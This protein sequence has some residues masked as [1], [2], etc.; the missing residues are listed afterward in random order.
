MICRKCKKEV[1]D[2]KYCSQCGASQEAKKHKPRRANGTGC[3]YK[4]SGNRSKP[5]RAVRA[6]VEDDDGN[7]IR[8]ELGTYRTKADAEKALAK[9]ALLPASEYSNITLKALFEMWKTTRAY[10][11]LSKQTQDNYSAAYIYLQS[12]HGMKFT[13]L[14]TAHFQKCVDEAAKEKSRST[15]EKIKALCTILSSY[16]YSQDVC[17][18]TYAAGIRL[19]KPE[20]RSIP[21]FTEIEIAQLFKHASEPIV[22]TILI[23]IYTGMRIRELLT[24]TKFSVDLDQWLITGGS[25]TDAGTD[26]IIPIHPKIQPLIKARYETAENFLIEQDKE[27]GNM[28]K[29]TLKTVRVP[30]R[31]EYY[32]DLYYATLERLGIRRLTP[33]KARHTFFTMLSDKCTDR[34]GMALV[35]GHSDPDFTD[36]TYVQP[37]I[38]RLRRV[39]ECL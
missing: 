12:I 31:Y 30:Y 24:L 35:G 19:P 26:R 4:L 21:T 1:P 22:D 39:I 5:W 16:A 18:K 36:K 14:R 28:K 3:V 2:G 6:S 27:I 7:T 23:L 34:K 15:L 9:D 8:V 32:S 17:F 38:E 10:T 29:G 13:D 20:K 37:D 11:D 25:K 33:H